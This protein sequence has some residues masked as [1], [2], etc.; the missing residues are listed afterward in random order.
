MSKSKN[1]KSVRKIEVYLKLY[2]L[3]QRIFFVDKMQ[4]A[5]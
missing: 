5:S 4:S 1:V 3:F 2:V